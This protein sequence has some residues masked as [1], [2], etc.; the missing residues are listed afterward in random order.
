MAIAGSLR[1]SSFYLDSADSSKSGKGTINDVVDCP[2]LA[3]AGLVPKL[4]PLVWATPCRLPPHPHLLTNPQGEVHP[5]LLNDS[6]HLMAWPISG[7][8]TKVRDFQLPLLDLLANP[9][10]SPRNDLMPVVGSDG[11]HGAEV[12]NWSRLIPMNTIS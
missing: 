6:L 2:L 11:L 10:G 4:L 9:S 7:D 8:P 3:A 1:F 12:R 5:M